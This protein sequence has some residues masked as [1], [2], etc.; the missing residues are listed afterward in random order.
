MKLHLILLVS[1]FN[2]SGALFV[3]ISDLRGP[4]SDLL[5]LHSAFSLTSGFIAELR[6]PCTQETCTLEEYAEEEEYLK[7][8]AAATLARSAEP[9]PTLPVLG[10]ETDPTLPVLAELEQEARGTYSIQFKFYGERHSIPEGGESAILVHAKLPSLPFLRGR[11]ARSKDLSTTRALDPLY[12]DCFPKNCAPR[13]DSSSYWQDLFFK[14]D[15]G[16][17]APPIQSAHTVTR[18][19]PFPDSL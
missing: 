8:C 18:S 1:L 3:A 11:F 13:Q 17:R 15:D 10:A 5:L 4:I 19:R 16:Q 7:S 12:R 6:S 2:L 9:D 14:G